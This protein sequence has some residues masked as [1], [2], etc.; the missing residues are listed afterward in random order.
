M[1]DIDQASFTLDAGDAPHATALEHKLST[2]TRFAVTAPAT[3]AQERC[4]AVA[5]AACLAH[6]THGST[7]HLVLRAASE[8]QIGEI[9]GRVRSLGEGSCAL[10]W[11]H[12]P[13]GAEFEADDI[14]G[15][16][17]SLDAAC[18]HVL[19]TADDDDDARAMLETVRD[20]C[21]FEELELAEVEEEADDGEG[22]LEAVPADWNAAYEQIATVVSKRTRK[23]RLTKDGAT[24]ELGRNSLGAKGGA[25]FMRKGGAFTEVNGY[26]V[27]RK[28]GKGAY[29]EVFAATKDG[30]RYALKI[31]KQSALKKVGGVGPRTGK[32][33]GSVLDSVGKEIATMKKIVHPNCVALFDVIADPATVDEICL[34]LEFVAGGESQKKDEA[35]MP[36]P[37]S[38]ATI[39]SHTRHLVMGLEYLHMHGI[40]HRDIKPENLMITRQ[41]VLKIADF[42]TSTLLDDPNAGTQQRVVGTP[43]FF[44]PELCTIE[45]ATV[46]RAH[47]VDLWAVGVTMYLWI[48][49]RTPFEAETQM[50]LMGKIRDCDDLVASPPEASADLLSPH[51]EGLGAVISGL[52]TKDVVNRTTLSQLRHHTWLTIGDTQPLPGQPVGQVFVSEAEVAMA[53]TNRQEIA[54]QSVAGPSTL[55]ATTGYQPN[56]K[57]EGLNAIR[58]KATAEEG[59][60][61]ARSNRHGAYSRWPIHAGP[62][63]PRPSRLHKHTLPDCL[64]L[65]T[66]VC[67]CVLAPRVLSAQPPSIAPWTIPATSRHTFLCCTRCASSRRPSWPPRPRRRRPKPAEPRTAACRRSRRSRTWAASRRRRCTRCRCRIS[68]PG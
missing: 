3:S 34:L 5:F 35:G 18:M 58:K 12:L 27:G 15:W 19:L 42:G 39:W 57:R 1:T 61:A 60:H 30:E 48:S 47:G 44:A 26:R 46:G 10:V 31:L 36:I 56:W 51:A 29:G 2:A 54:Y 8:D 24:S 7:Y 40:I 32:S 23:R 21:A 16:V 13:A 67:A 20:A 64:H 41:G 22:E 6:A 52:L 38:C 50:L 45:G 9:D 53:F 17:E 65:S 4:V 68:R 28:L 37:L 25:S 55:G 14:I 66:C 62:I 11:L 43:H 49:G 63:H 59:V 33:T